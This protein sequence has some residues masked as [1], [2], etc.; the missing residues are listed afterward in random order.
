MVTNRLLKIFLGS[1]HPHY[2][3]LVLVI[4]VAVLGMA[5][6]IGRKVGAF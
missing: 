2:H 4:E 3:F 1:T 5:Y 6:L